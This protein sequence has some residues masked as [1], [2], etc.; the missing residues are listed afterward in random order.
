[1]NINQNVM[2]KIAISFFPMCFL[3]VLT[4]CFSFPQYQQLFTLGEIVIHKNDTEKKTL[5]LDSA[6]FDPFNS[7]EVYY[8]WQLENRTCP[9][10]T[11]LL[12][13]EN[14]TTESDYESQFLNN[15]RQV[16]LSLYRH[17][18]YIVPINELNTLTTFN[19]FFQEHVLLLVNIITLLGVIVLGIILFIYIVKHS[20]TQ[21]DINNA[22]KNQYSSLKNLNLT[23]MVSSS[24]IKRTLKI[25]LL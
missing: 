6:A 13:N 11:V 16:Y 24:E 25:S 15:T 17:E 3:F 19:L 21:K 5:L 4:L 23:K 1:M 7:S 18:A 14:T 2:K 20:L 9:I 10:S 22:Y 8:S 12:F